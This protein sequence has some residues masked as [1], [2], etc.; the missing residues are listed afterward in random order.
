MTQVTGVPMRIRIVPPILIISF[1]FATGMPLADDGGPGGRTLTVLEPEPGLERLDPA[2]EMVMEKVDKDLRYLLSS[3]F[4]LTPRG[5]A[6][7]GVTLI[8]SLVLLNNDAGFH[9]DISGNK[10]DRYDDIY[11]PFREFDDHLIEATA[12]FYLLGYLLEDKGIK[13]DTLLALES[14]ALSALFAGVPA[15]VIGRSPPGDGEGDKKYEPFEK[16]GSLP[17]VNSAVIFSMAGALSRERGI[18][19]TLFWY[20]VAT[21]VGL[22]RIYYDDAWPSDVFLGAV[23]GAAIGRSVADLSDGGADAKVRLSPVLDALNNRYGLGMEL[24]F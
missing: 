6:I 8:T 21:G 2:F 10:K 3:P 11:H 4:R 15:M 9:E 18:L 19:S 1:F 14:A 13:S 12:G 17:D 5:K 7:V 24:R 22:S 16:V 20:G 23:I